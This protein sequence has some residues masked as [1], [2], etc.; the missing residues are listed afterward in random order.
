[1]TT[2]VIRCFGSAA[3]AKWSAFL[4]VSQPATSM[5]RSKR[6]LLPSF[7]IVVLG[8]GAWLSAA[9]PA[10]ATDRLI[11]NGSGCQVT[12]ED[13]IGIQLHQDLYLRIDYP[14]THWRFGLRNMGLKGTQVLDIAVQGAQYTSPQ[15]IVKRAGLAEMFV[16]YDDRS[17]TYYDMSFGDD[18]MDQMDQADLPATNSAL[19]YFRNQVGNLY[20]RDSVP[21]VGVECR[22]EGVGWLCKEPNSHVRRRIQ[23]VVVWSV[24]DAY[25]YDYIIEYTF[26]ED[27]RITFR[28]GATGYNLPGDTSEPH[29]HNAFWRVSTKLLGRDDNESVEFVHVEDSNGYIATDSFLPI[30]TEETADWN[31]L[32]FS[33]LLVQSQTQT[34]DYGHLVGYQFYPYNRQGTGHFQETWT[35]H[36]QDLTNDNPGEDGTGTGINNWLYTWYNPNSY[37]LTYL[38]GQP[39]GGTGDGIVLWYFGSAHHEPTDADNQMGNDGRTGITLV[40]WS[41][42]EMMPHN[43]FDYNPLGGPARCG[44]GYDLNDASL[45]VGMHHHH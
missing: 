36:D 11:I 39:L 25:N 5:S 8:I 27:G 44:T 1:M 14:N 19:V 20:V 9:A 43:F 28:S 32:Q 40:H 26:H 38:N 42:F 12:E 24:Y 23:E 17:H 15:Y 30:P 6:S 2:S 21:K 37:L 33:N 3:L 35:Q 10:H 4:G 18:R 22:D 29:V 31:P 13:A 16:P 45:L 34:N 7:L 41:G